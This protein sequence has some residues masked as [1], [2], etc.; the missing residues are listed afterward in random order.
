MSNRDEQTLRKAPKNFRNDAGNATLVTEPVIGVVKSTI[1]SIRT[2]RIYVYIERFGAEDPDNPNSW[3]PVRYMSPFYGLTPTTSPDNGYGTFEGNAHSYGIWNSPPD[4]GTQVIC[5]FIDG[6]TN[7]GYYIGCIPEPE[8]LHMVPAMGAS[9]NIV[10]GEGE[11]ESFGGATRLP[12]VNINNNSPEAESSNFLNLA[13]PVHT[14]QSS[15]YFQ[16]GL[17]RDPI[18][19]PI[20]SS[21][22]RESPSRVGWGVSSPGRPIY[23]GGL[24]DEAAA[25]AESSDSLRIIG[26]RG[27]HSIVLDDGDVN[28]SDQLMR[29]RTSLGHQIMMSDSGQTLFIIHSNGQSYIELGKE[30]TVDIYSTNSINLRTQGDL[31]LHADSNININAAK[32][33]NLSAEEI[34]IES[35]KDTNFRIG[36]NFSEYTVGKFTLKV[37]GAMSLDSGGEASVKSAAITYINGSK[38]NLNTGSAGLVPEVVKPI[39]QIAQTDTLYDDTKGYAAA[40]GKLMT[41]VSRAP[42]HSP[43]ANAG[44]GV[45]VKTDISASAQLPSSPS[46]AVAA[47]NA[48]VPAVPANPLSAK[49]AATVPAMPSVGP[50]NSATMGALVGQ[51][52]L[53][54]AAG[55]AGAAVAAGSGVVSNALGQATAAV[56]ALA[57]SPQQLEAAGILKPGSASLVNNL[58]QNGANVASAMTNNLFTGKGGASSLTQLT[59]SIPAQ[60]Q[61]AGSV[62]T[63]ATAGLITA[64]AIT[65]K[66]SPQVTAGIVNAAATVGLG[67]TIDFMKNA[68]TGAAIGGLLSKSPL[69]AVAGAV[70]GAMS[71]GKFAGGL[72]ASVTGGLG[73]LA[74]SLSGLTKSIGAGL[75]GALDSAKGV[76]GAAFSAVTGA[77]K[78]LTP[79]VPQNLTAIAGANAIASEAASGASPASIAGGLAGSLGG[80]GSALAGAAVGSILG[81]NPLSGLA[82]AAIGTALSGGLPNP[83][84][85]FGGAGAIVGSITGAANTVIAGIGKSVSTVV[86]SVTTLVTG[87]VNSVTSGLTGIPGGQGAISN[88]VNNMN[89]PLGAISGAIGGAVSGI[90]GGIA[91]AVGSIGGIAKAA[92]GGAT[93]L[94][95][96]GGNTLAGLASSVLPAGLSNQI[97]AAIGS[98]GSGGSVPIK[99]P[100]IAVNTFTPPSLGSLF[101]GGKSPIPDFSAVPMPVDQSLERQKQLSAQIQSLTKQIENQTQSVTDARIAYTNAKISLP[102][103]DPEVASLNAIWD[104]ELAKLR[105]L[106][107]EASKLV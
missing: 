33:F 44:Q 103:D 23:E 69:G 100:T 83:G 84:S 68:A 98:L 12:V 58:V 104:N 64:G 62:I 89:N 22:Q 99:I 71:A 37:D 51:Q 8:A 67:P 96:K 26:R 32:K 40:P 95:K 3:T 97:N 82:G 55:A 27:G 24:S 19:G 54:A 4:I 94:L 31:N 56:G 46:P 20:S 60:I 28:G 13:K 63:N 7:Y 38:V 42:A 57:Q 59:N 86:G 35:Q 9:D 73:G 80:V 36:A 91:G 70:A 88:I 77:F 16:Q 79:G 39:P 14:Y 50:L 93:D 102:S 48:S 75:T 6:K 81:K 85:A 11:A 41:I 29:L 30:G 107:K 90:T 45:D 76:A 2:G 78:A 5:I 65:G 52:S 15:I 25:S 92:L 105:Q 10:A 61:A 18:R 74:G 1:D 53:S 21:A 47:A 72:A 66:E 101:G 87:A 43:W 49:V 34:N 17:L 106:Q